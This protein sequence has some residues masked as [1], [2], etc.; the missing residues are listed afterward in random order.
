MASNSVMA[1]AGTRDLPEGMTRNCFQPWT[2][3]EIKTNGDVSPCCVRPPVGNIGSGSL[4]GILNGA[5]LRQ[6]RMDLLTGTLDKAC[7]FCRLKTYTPVDAFVKSVE[8]M[9]S[10]L[11][12]PENFNPDAYLTANPDVQRA[13][14]D[15]TTHFLRWGRLEGRNLFP[16][17]P[18]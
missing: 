8:Q 3:V 5:A 11:E 9:L 13:G 16:D 10:N 4:A 17:A 6:L 7:K 2:H 14:F 1:P 18:G 12:V 15:P